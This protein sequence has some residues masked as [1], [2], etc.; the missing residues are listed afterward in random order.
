MKNTRLVMLSARFKPVVGG[1]EKQ[2]LALAKQLQKNGLAIQVLTA[3]LKGLPKTESVEG[4]PVRRLFSAGAGSLGTWSFM[5]SSFIYLVAKRKNYD[6]I[7]VFLAG[8]PAISAAL[9]GKLIGK[10]VALKLGGAGSTGDVG[11]STRTAIGRHKLGFIKRWI[12]VFIVPT[13]EIKN[14]L[15]AQ[16]FSGS[17]IYQIPNGVDIDLFKPAGSSEKQELRRELGLPG[18]KIVTYAGRLEAGKGVETLLAGWENVSQK[19]P[20][21]HLLILG[22]GRLKYDLKA[23]LY[24]KTYRD[25]VLMPGQVEDITKYLRSSDVFVLPSMAEGMS[26]ALLEAASCGL[27]LVATAIGGTTELIVHGRNGLLVPAGDAQALAD[28]IVLLLGNEQ[29]MVTLGQT[30][31]QDVTNSYSLNTIA[32]KYADLYENIAEGKNIDTHN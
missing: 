9:A 21:A 28:Q 19:F 7:Q 24:G 30:A 23:S 17:K 3:R 31:R 15:E 22:D 26:N 4:V 29:E 1:T 14:E 25:G 8:S 16:G 10:K 32:G 27:A 6:L 13:G 11:T 2:A 12:D 18:E 5:I 20:Q